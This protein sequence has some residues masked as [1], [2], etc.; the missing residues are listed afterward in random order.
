MLSSRSLHFVVLGLILGASAGYVFAFYNAQ[1]PLPASLPPSHPPVAADPALE[2]L[3][4]AVDLNPQNPEIMSRY[5]TALFTANRTDEAISYWERAVGLRPDDQDLRSALGAVLWSQGRPDEARRH[6]QTSLQQNPR[7]VRTLHAFFFLALETDR[8]E[9]RA[10]EI[11]KTI[12][13]IDPGYGGLPDLRE[14]L[15][16][17]R[18]TGR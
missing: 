9:K 13:G 16:A 5:A 1:P 18:S 10:A 17:P 15:K 2:S 7:H 14:R 6:L 4:N 12:E 11:V 8:D 3:K